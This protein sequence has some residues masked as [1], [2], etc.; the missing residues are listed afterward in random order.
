MKKADLKKIL[1]DN[2]IHYFSYWGKQKLM[3]LAGDHNL[4]SPQK[5]KPKKKKTQ[6]D[7]GK[8]KYVNYERLKHIRHTPT[9][10][11]LKDV[12]TEE[13]HQF[14]SIYKAA[15]FIDKA[16]QT[17]RHWGQKKGVWND[18]FQVTLE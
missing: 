8:P 12:K 17:I 13:E 15:Q 14:P 3:D 1:K 11:I 9:K 16:P 7:P 18:A 5:E 10:V 2:K 6:E 4:L